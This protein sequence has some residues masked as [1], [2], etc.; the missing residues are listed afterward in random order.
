MPVLTKRC[1]PRFENQT[2]RLTMKP[3]PSPPISPP[4]SAG[5]YTMTPPCRCI[6]H[7][8]LRVLKA[9]Y[10]SCFSF[11]MQGNSKGGAVGEGRKIG[12]TRSLRAAQLRSRRI[13]RPGSS[14]MLIGVV[15]LLLPF[16]PPHFILAVLRGWG[17]ER[18]DRS[19][20]ATAPGE[21]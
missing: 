16:H 20:F 11:R 14:R 6:L 13:F 18:T 7:L 5:L 1:F 9:T 3:S 12:E 10:A 17:S 8:P 19:F 4:S 15:I 21:F 2:K